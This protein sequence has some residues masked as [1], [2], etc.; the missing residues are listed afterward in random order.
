MHIRINPRHTAQ[1]Q[2]EVVRR[3]REIEKRKKKRKG[4]ITQRGTG[5]EQRPRR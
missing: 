4:W 3:E 2:E 5:E 1:R